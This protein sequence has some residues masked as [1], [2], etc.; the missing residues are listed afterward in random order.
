MGLEVADWL[1]LRGAKKLILTSRV[2]VVDGYQKMRINL[3]KSYGTTVVVRTDD[4]AKPHEVENLLRV[5]ENLGPVCA[6]FNLALVSD[7]CCK[8]RGTVE[9]RNFPQRNA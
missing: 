3:W 7:S 1:V 4:V 2:G 8:L 6:I 9:T 5:A